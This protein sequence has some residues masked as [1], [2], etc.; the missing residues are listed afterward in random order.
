MKKTNTKENNTFFTA[1]TIVESES[2]AELVN[3][4]RPEIYY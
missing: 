2:L 1:A 4:N 3:D